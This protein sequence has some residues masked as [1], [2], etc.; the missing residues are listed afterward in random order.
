MLEILNTSEVVLL[1]PAF[2]LCTS[3]YVFSYSTGV[4]DLIAHFA[5]IVCCISCCHTDL[6]LN[7]VRLRRAGT[8]DVKSR[9][10]STNNSIVGNSQLLDSRHKTE[11]FSRRFTAN[12]QLRG[13]VDRGKGC[14]NDAINGIQCAKGEHFN[15]SGMAWRTKRDL[16]PS[17][18]TFAS[19]WLC[20]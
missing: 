11:F 8:R 12:L 19:I 1:G 17:G 15:N 4:S 9:R 6:H 16:V 7:L 13:G 18:S 3:R 5:N 2:L 14:T 10:S 20:P